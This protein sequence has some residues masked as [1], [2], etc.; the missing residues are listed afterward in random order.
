MPDVTKFSIFTRN[1][2]GMLIK[3]VNIQETFSIACKTLYI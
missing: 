3:F 1:I 2:L